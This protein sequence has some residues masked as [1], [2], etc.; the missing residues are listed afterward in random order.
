MCRYAFLI[1]SHHVTS[2]HSSLV[3]SDGLFGRHRHPLPHCIYQKASKVTLYPAVKWKDTQQG[4]L[5]CQLEGQPMGHLI[6]HCPMGNHCRGHFVSLISGKG[7]LESTLSGYLL[8]HW[9]HH[10]S[11]WFSHQNKFSPPPFLRLVGVSCYSKPVDMFFV[12][13]RAALRRSHGWRT[14][15][16]T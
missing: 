9:V 8:P 10:H 4:N 11:K 2:L 1:K 6:D 16:S 12:S 14:W 13:L 5:L 15:R 7:I 3:W